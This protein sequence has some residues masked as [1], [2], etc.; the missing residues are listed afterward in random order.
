MAVEIQTMVKWQA[1]SSRNT[2]VVGIRLGRALPQTSNKIA[3]RF[4]TAMKDKRYESDSAY[5]K[6]VEQKLGRS[7]IF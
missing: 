2:R 4:E 3:D 7:S 1:F 5:T 6:D